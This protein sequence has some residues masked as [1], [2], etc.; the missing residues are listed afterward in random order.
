M[1]QVRYIHIY[2]PHFFLDFVYDLKSPPI[3]TRGHPETYASEHYSTANICKKISQPSFSLILHKFQNIYR[4][5]LHWH[6]NKSTCCEWPQSLVCHC[7]N[8]KI[9]TAI[10]DINAQSYLIYLKQL[11]FPIQFRICITNVCNTELISHKY[12]VV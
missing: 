5:Q 2:R 1:L 10:H 8:S 4:Y 6:V 3:Q 12:S 7:T 11:V 9:Y